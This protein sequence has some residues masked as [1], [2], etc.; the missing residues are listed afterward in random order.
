MY[1]SVFC[2]IQQDRRTKRK[3]SDS[4]L[5]KKKKDLKTHIFDV[6]G[7]DGLAV[8]VDGS[9]CDDDDVQPRPGCA[10]LEVNTHIKADLRD[11]RTSFP[12]KQPH[13]SHTCRP[14]CWSVKQKR[15]HSRGRFDELLPSYR[16]QTAAHA[17]F[18]SL[19]G[20]SLRYEEPVCPR[21]Q[22]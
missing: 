14:N 13:F 16:F 2:F 19:L 12:E 3:E 11:C 4:F 5:K 8:H 10:A 7:G 21:G 6:S 20:W 9:F 15:H 18:P 22:C 17:V 1:F